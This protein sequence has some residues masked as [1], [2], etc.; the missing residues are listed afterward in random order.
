MTQGFCGFLLFLGGGGSCGEGAG[1]TASTGPGF[2]SVLLCLQIR[3]KVKTF[4]SIKTTGP[5]ASVHSL[6][7]V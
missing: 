1:C 7:E 6:F 5:L 2:R 3:K 4:N